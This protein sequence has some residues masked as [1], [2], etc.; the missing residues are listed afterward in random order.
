MD[1]FSLPHLLVILLI[2]LVVFGTKKLQSAATDLGSAIKS[3]RHAMREEDT[4]PAH[5]ETETKKLPND[6]SGKDA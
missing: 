3:F 5:K 2:V 1:F 6:T 4:S